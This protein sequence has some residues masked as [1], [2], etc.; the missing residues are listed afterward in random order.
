MI[1]VSIKNAGGRTTFSVTTDSV[2]LQNCCATVSMNV[3]T[4]VMSQNDVV[5]II[6]SFISLPD[7]A[8][9]IFLNVL[10]FKLSVPSKDLKYRS[11]IQ[12]IA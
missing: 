8:R 11:W 3:V 7:G 12:W 1:F 9:S 4:A 5:S 2:C 10:M 6:D